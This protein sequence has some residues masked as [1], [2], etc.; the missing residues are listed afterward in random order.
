MIIKKFEK[1]VERFGQKPAVKT[2]NKILTYKELNQIANQIALRLIRV[3]NQLV[4]NKDKQRVSLLFAHGAD[5][6]AA[7]LGVLKAAKTYI[8]LD[9]TYPEKRLSY[10]LENSQSYLILTDNRNL[11]LAEQLA[12]RSPGDMEILNIDGINPE[13]QDTNINYIDKEIP[14]ETPAYILY[15]SGSTGNPKGVIQS[16][17]NILHHVEAWTRRFVITAADRMTLLASFSHDG[18]VPDIYS[19]LLNGAT[20]YP[21]DIKQTNIRE[22]VQLLV[23]EKIT[24]WH[25]VPTFYRYFTNQ[26]NGNEGFPD[27]RLVILGGE[28]VRKDDL[29]LFKRYFSYS[30][31]ANIYGQT[32]S[33]VNSIWLVSPGEDP[34]QIEIGEPVDDTQMMLVN[35]DGDIVG[36]MGVG[37]IVV[38]SDYVGL[39]YWQEEDLTRK[40]FT[41]DDQMG[42]LYWTGDLGR[43]TADGRIVILGRKDLQVK[44]RGFRVE[45]GEIESVLL[46]H[47]AVREIAAVLKANESAA[48][49][50]CAYVVPTPGK[51]DIDTQ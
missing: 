22:M 30:N 41:Y 36:D 24:I 12:E 43:Y 5:M 29:I 10:I 11:A 21:I 34:T 16:H 3:D 38:A 18:S 31:F 51:K 46:R 48:S 39:G 45:L 27:F 25:S 1:Q 26:L 28:A 4:E 17:R 42:R 44:I 9:V 23:K 47:E 14:G 33:T 35:D 8:P 20:L 15:T 49:Y 7:L 19:S 40:V 6:I 2:D 37:E 13:N 32:E 50:I